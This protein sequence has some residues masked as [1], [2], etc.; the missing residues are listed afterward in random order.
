[1]KLMNK[2][3][4]FKSF[5]TMEH[6]PVTTTYDPKTNSRQTCQT[7]IEILDTKIIRPNTAHSELKKR[8]CASLI[9]KGYQGT[10]RPE[11]LVFKTNSNPNYAIPFDIMALTNGKTFTSTDYYRKFLKGSQK[12][13]C[14]TVDEMLAKYPTSNK[15]IVALNEFRRKHKLKAINPNSMNYNECCFTNEI[16]IIP[17]ALIGQSYKYK[18]LANQYNI[19]IY[20]SSH[21]FYKE[22]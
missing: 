1:M 16:K 14:D 11:G 3:L 8:L 2:K 20:E 18:E 10:Y 9:H 5:V 7:L 12:F 22:E 4:Y 19:P 15:A 17:I 21:D 13:H 6:M